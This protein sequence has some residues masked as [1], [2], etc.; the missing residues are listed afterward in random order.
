MYIFMY[1]YI[2]KSIHICTY[3][4]IFIYLA[5]PEVATRSALTKPSSIFCRKALQ[6]R[7]LIPKRTSQSRDFRCQHIRHLVQSANNEWDSSEYQISFANRALQNRA[8]CLKMTS[9]FRDF[10]FLSVKC[11]VQ[12]GND[13]WAP[14]KYQ[15]SWAR[16]SHKKRTFFQKRLSNTLTLFSKR[17][18]QNRA[19]FLNMT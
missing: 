3:I 5:G 16:E 1:V 10:R 2:Y 18:I 9:Q 17:A 6:H 15:I 13:Q 11:M 12:G 19:L 14:S 7:T 8:L 4:R